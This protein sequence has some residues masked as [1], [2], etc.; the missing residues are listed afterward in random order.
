MRH[1]TLNYKIKNSLK[2]WQIENCDKYTTTSKKSAKSHKN[3][4][5][6]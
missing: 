5:I 6:F 2:D 3:K 1:I 4:T